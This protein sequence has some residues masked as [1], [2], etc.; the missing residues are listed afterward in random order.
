MAALI[1]SKHIYHSVPLAIQRALWIVCGVMGFVVVGLIV[2]KHIYH[3][4]PLAI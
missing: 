3:A 2:S 4:V 1:V